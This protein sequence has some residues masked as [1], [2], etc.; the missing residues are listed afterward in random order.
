MSCAGTESIHVSSNVSRTKTGLL[1]RFHKGFFSD[2]W[3][4]EFFVLYVDSTLAWFDDQGSY[5]PKGGILLK[6]VCQFMAVGVTTQYI[7][8][9]IPKLPPGA[10]V[11]NLMAVPKTRSKSAEFVWVLCTDQNELNSW[12]QAIMTVLPPPPQPPPQQQGGPPPQYGGGGGQPV[13]PPPAQQ[14]YPPPPHPAYGQRPPHPGYQGHPQGGYRGN[15]PQTVVINQGGRSRRGSG[16][17]GRD[18]ATGMLIGGAMG[19]GMARP[20]G[21]GWGYGGYGGFGSGISI[22]NHYDIDHTHIENNTFQENNYD[23]G[24]GDYGGGGYDGGDYGGGGDYYDG[25]GDF[26]GGD[27]GGGDFGGGDFGGGDFGGGD[28]GGG[29]FGDCGD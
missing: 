19:Y 13:Y 25:G 14:G 26:G 2:K 29:D 5:E 28:F 16:G 15:Q 10:E 11:T 27:F 18:F 20:W 21:W 22:N 17:S 9:G 1:R 8:G 24:G 12:L 7:P 3:R 23:F 6:D 4:Q